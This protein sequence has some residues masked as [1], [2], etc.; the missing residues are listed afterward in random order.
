MI[1]VSFRYIKASHLDASAAVKLV[2][3]ER[4]CEHLSSY[5]AN[6][7]GFYITSVCLA[8]ALGVF[9]RKRVRDELSEKQYLATC[10]LLLGY[11]RSPPRIRVDEIELSSLDTFAKAEEIARRH[12]LDFSDSLQLISVKHRR[13]S[14]CVPGFKTVFI[15]ADRALASAAKAEGLRV[16]NCEEEAASPG[17]MTTADEA[18]CDV[19]PAWR[20]ERNSAPRAFDSAS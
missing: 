13:S 1:I 6:R 5:F 18:I 9:K 8:E 2:L 3:Q 16:W 19:A 20:S 10:N 12:K 4:G 11:L 7:A 14:S 17:T 15:T